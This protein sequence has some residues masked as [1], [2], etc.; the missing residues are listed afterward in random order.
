MFWSYGAYSGSLLISL[1]VTAVLARLLTP[2]EFG[3]VALALIFVAIMDT[4]PGLGVNDALVVV[5]DADLE[6][7]AETA[8]LVAT[9][10]GLGLAVVMAALGPVAAR[11]FHQPQLTAIM[12]VLGISFFVLGLGITHGAIAQKQMDFRARN[13]ATLADGLARGVVGVLLALSGAGVWSLVLGYVAGSCASTLTMWITVPWRPLFRPR[14]AHLGHLLGFGGTLTGVSVMSAFLTQFDFL[15]VGRV[16]GATSLGFYSMATRLP[17]YAILGLGTVAG[18]ILFPAFATLQDEDV[19]RAFI[20]SLQYSALVVLPLAVFLGVLAEPITIAVFG[21]QWGPSVG[22]LQV[23]CVWAAATTFLYVAGSAF[24]A[25]KRPDLIFKLTIPQAITLVIGSLVL[26]RYGIVAV[27]LVQAGIALY[28]VVLAVVVAKHLFGFSLQELASAVG[29]PAI[30]AAF[31]GLDVWVVNHLM[32]GPWPTILVAGATGFLGYLVVV[33][34]LAR[35][36]VS[37]IRT[38]AFPRRTVPAT[39]PALE[40]ALE[41]AERSPLP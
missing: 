23:L 12:P 39:D 26:V 38:I 41:V 14:R 17:G 33:F 16:L 34:A 25:R 4:F 2:D 5:P 15:V 32:S 10:V 36:S 31:L 18:R 1:M 27:S 20:R 22:A 13:R 3:L 7:N 30:A 19:R 40:R 28:S 6:E 8:F 24:K 9:S 11:F 37:E 21:D 35:E 29:P